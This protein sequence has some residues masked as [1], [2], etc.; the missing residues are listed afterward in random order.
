MR[1]ILRCALCLTAAACVNLMPPNMQPAAVDVPRRSFRYVGDTLILAISN[2]SQEPSVS[3]RVRSAIAATVRSAFPAAVVLDS[4][5]DSAPAPRRV[6]ITATLVQY[7]A[8]WEGPRWIG[9]TGL[10]VFV[11][12]YRVSS[13]SEF[14]DLIRT[15][16]ASSIVN[17]GNK[18]IGDVSRASFDSAS[19]ALI[20][21]LDSLADP[22]TRHKPISTAGVSDTEYAPYLAPTGNSSL[23]GRAF[24]T[25]AGRE[26]PAAN[27]PVTLD[28]ATSSSRRWYERA[29]MD[30][31]MF[32]SESPDDLFRRTRRTTMTDSHGQFAFTALQPGTYI[33]RVRVDWNAADPNDLFHSVRPFT[34]VVAAVVRVEDGVP[35]QIA[36]NQT[37]NAFLH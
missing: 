34:A 12:D 35:Q 23:T 18:T 31:T 25:A 6:F 9:H 37:G 2:R 7:G 29:G 15:S 33:V 26:H 16:S 24:I 10:D 3:A 19:M 5:V 27:E 1:R 13:N 11:R 8:S 30:W 36:V 17:M 4:V 14:V 21:F 20:A 28:P 22:S 32:N